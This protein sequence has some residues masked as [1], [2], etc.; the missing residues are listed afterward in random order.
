MSEQAT[1][2]SSYGTESVLHEILTSFSYL[3]RVTVSYRVRN[4]EVHPLSNG[5]NTQLTPLERRHYADLS[6]LALSVHLGTGRP[7]FIGDKV[8]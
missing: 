4:C 7:E 2:V 3:E 1:V 8:L 6:H 5:S